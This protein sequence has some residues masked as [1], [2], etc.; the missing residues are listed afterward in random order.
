MSS[1]TFSSHRNTLHP[2]RRVAASSSSQPASDEWVALR[3]RHLLPFSIQQAELR[4]AELRQLFLSPRLA[5]HE[6]YQ[7]AIENYIQKQQLLQ[8]VRNVKILEKTSSS[9]SS[10]RYSYERLEGSSRCFPFTACGSMSYAPSLLVTGSCDGLL[11]LWDTE[12]CRPLASH[13]GNDGISSRSPVRN[14]HGDL[15]GSDGIIGDSSKEYPVMPPESDGVYNE[16]SEEESRGIGG[17]APVKA[18]VAHPTSPLFFT[19]TMFDA[20]IRGWKVSSEEGKTV[21]QALQET[22]KE[23][24]EEEEEREWSEGHSPK[25][26]SV[27]GHRPKSAASSLFSYGSG[28]THIRPI[29]TLQM[30]SSSATFTAHEKGPHRNRQNMA[31]DPS[32]RLLASGGANGM[33]RVW[34]V[35]GVVGEVQGEGVGNSFSHSIPYS[36]LASQENENWYSPG[37][38]ASSSSFGS[39]PPVVQW[40]AEG[41]E[42]RKET[43]NIN[44]I[45]FH[46]DGALLSTGDAGGRIVTWDLRSGKVA[47]HTTFSTSHAFSSPRRASGG[48]GT[49]VY[50]THLK[51]VT[52]MAW[53]LCG[54]RLASG[55][56]DGVVQLWDARQLYRACNTVTTASSTSSSGDT[57]ERPSR[58]NDTVLH[59]PSASYSHL[60]VGH[61]D[62]ITSLSFRSCPPVFFKDNQGGVS[63]LGRRLPL[64]LVTT[65]LDHTVRWWDMNTGVCVKVMHAEGPVRGHTWMNGGTQDGS[66]VTIVHGKYWSLWGPGSSTKQQLWDNDASATDRPCETVD[67]VEVLRIP[68]RQPTG[69]W[70]GID[71]KEDD[72]KEE[73]SEEEEDEMKALQ[74]EVVDIEGGNRDKWKDELS[75]DEEDDEED[76]MAMLKR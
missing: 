54:E 25:G 58:T 63:V 50:H 24:Q 15:H 42:E 23:K 46:P 3:V 53:S 44:A 73:L 10:H 40:S 20:A 52:C 18:I 39:C 48:R 16:N 38:G 2:V 21:A 60:L 59:A 43:A 11:T 61:E 1:S 33:V 5:V 55:G 12:S 19:R 57:S 37:E 62:E 7:Y 45:A 75:E 71:G 27:A 47:F 30:G 28:A 41:R 56:T 49:V 8:H 64:A 69:K 31:I 36:A 4:V 29:C 76:E 32:G 35:R 51:A 65:S 68:S 67:T 74:R 72:A 34:D 17:V 13:P 9:D 70:V 26:T 22:K 6:A 14:P 66:L